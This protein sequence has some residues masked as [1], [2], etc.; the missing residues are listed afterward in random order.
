MQNQR[1]TSIGYFK[2]LQEPSVVMEELLILLLILFQF[3]NF[4]QVGMRVG[5]SNFCQLYAYTP[6]LT[7]KKCLV[8]I[9]II[10]LLWYI[11]NLIPTSLG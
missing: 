4:C 7:S 9:Q 6:S 11:T 3:S 1:T 10:A 2:T 8:Q 5:L